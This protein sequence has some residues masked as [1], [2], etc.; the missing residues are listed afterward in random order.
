MFIKKSVKT[1]KK[2]GKKYFSYQ[3]VKSIRTEKGPRQKI[4]LNL[5][6]KLDLTKKEK[7]ILANRI[8]EI[9][10]GITPLFIICKKIEKLAQ[11]FATFLI[12]KE[13]Q[14]NE[15]K[16]YHEIDI[17]TIDHEQPRTVGI[18]SI[19]FAAIKELELDKKLKELKLSKRQ[20]Q[21]A[22][23]SI[24]GKLSIAGSELAIYKWLK[25]ES[26]IDEV[27]ETDF[28]KLS[29]RKIYEITD[30]LLSHKEE[31]EIH[32]E[33][34]ERD[35]FG[36]KESIVLYD[37]TNTYFEGRPLHTKAK[38]G[39]SKEKRTDCLLITL[40]L[41][42]N[43]KGFIKKSHIFE[44]NVAEVTTLKKIIS[45]LSLTKNPIIVMDAGVASNDNL[46]WLRDKNHPYIVV[47]RSK[48]DM[49]DPNYKIIKKSKEN[50]IKG[51]FKNNEETGEIE[52]HCHSTD[53]QKKEEDM[54]TKFQE[55]FEKKLQ[56]ISFSKRKKSY[57][58]VLEMIGRLKQKYPIIAPYYEIKV[59]PDKEKKYLSAITWNFQKN[60]AEKRFL[61]KYIL[62]ANQ[63]ALSEK[64]L[65]ETYV[66]LTEVE[67]SFRCMKSE[68][69]LRPIYHQKE[70][71][72]DAHLFLTVLAY[73]VMH[74]IRHK[75]RNKNLKYSWKTIRSIMRTQI[76]VTSSMKTKEGKV[77]R[78]RK[79]TK[80][81][82]AHKEIYNALN[83]SPSIKP[84]K[85]II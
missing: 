12:R 14:I 79:T 9:I 23:G 60:R 64:E 70:K 16:E 68:L 7:K 69:G 46:K 47:S 54:Q 73:H 78:I 30:L 28:K 45:E 53:R 58:K 5:G 59:I 3:L 1:D 31:L 25:N 57:T 29:L 75:L 27:L 67:D 80:T 24:I 42:L 50:I 41:V 36:L 37:L 76:R 26:G 52:L 17:N 72:I 38:R 15:Q 10:S 21:L 81:E 39:R 35:L 77:I 4:L 63:V 22:I 61:G 43:Q 18:E 56:K 34:T 84:T 11:F 2:T 55:C 74:I 33:N 6:S 51:C 49:E 82:L 44:G 66:M 20:E 13:S 32:L 65:W 71:R 40:G 62:R 19:S 8:E 48:K 85:F 83:V